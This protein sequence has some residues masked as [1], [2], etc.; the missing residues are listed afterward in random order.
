MDLLSF[1]SK[2]VAIFSFTLFEIR[3]CEWPCAL[4]LQSPPLSRTRTKRI[5]QE[6][7]NRFSLQAIKFN[8][9]V[10]M[11]MIAVWVVVIACALSSIFSQ[12][13]S[14]RQKFF[15]TVFVI[16]V[17][18]VG[19]LAYLPFSFNREDLPDIFFGKSQHKQ[20]KRSQRGPIQRLPG[21]K[22]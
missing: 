16:A 19:V 10:L 1:S 6:I 20:A 9:F 2:K 7:L 15:W 14:R 17:P 11:A 13:F 5:M 21:P 18:L 3:A 8:T 12:P 22:K 4:A